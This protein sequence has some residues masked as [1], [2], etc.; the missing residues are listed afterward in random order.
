M[1]LL[2][3]LDSPHARK[4]KL[5]VLERNLRNRI[6]M[7]PMTV[8]QGDQDALALSFPHG[9]D[10]VL[11]DDDGYALYDSRVICAFLD[12]IHEGERLYPDRGDDRWTSLV[13]EALADSLIQ[14]VELAHEEQERRPKELR[15]RNYL[16]G[17]MDKIRSCLS[18]L[19]RKWVSR[20]DRRFDIATISIASALGHVEFR[21]PELRW[22]PEYPRLA[23]WY[24]GFSRRPSM[25][26][27]E[28]GEETR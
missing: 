1:R 22:R 2:Y 20:L 25:K 13:G 27:T 28:P 11:V 9:T 8:A 14:A 5:I 17:Q 3:S 12:T 6:S 18:E 7:I 19:E 4:A 21:L 26:A 16:R 24:A 23:A 10:A 15:W